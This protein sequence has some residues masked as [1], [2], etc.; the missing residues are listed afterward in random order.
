MLFKGKRL[1][2]RIAL[3]A[4]LAVFAAGSL[5][6]FAAPLAPYTDTT[7]PAAGLTPATASADARQA[8]RWV[9][10]ANDNQ[11]LPFVIVDKKGGR[12]FVF[13]AN[14]QLRGASAALTG[15]APGDHAVPGMEQ[16]S[17]ASL[18]DYERTTPAGRFV[19]EPGHNLQGEA[20][21]W[22]DYAAKLAIHRLRPAPAAERRAER[23]ASETPDDNRISMGCV[24]VPVSF[25]ETVVGPVLGKSRSIVY[26]LPETQPL[27]RMLGALQL[28]QR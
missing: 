23:L 27:Q 26:V 7:A 1:H 19:S 15:L 28:S 16:R 6:A 22:I 8:L 18:R 2:T 14:G 3:A 4:V 5:P 25:Y 13:E 21:V 12:I 17:V 20:I 11:G 9:V 10:E 24:V